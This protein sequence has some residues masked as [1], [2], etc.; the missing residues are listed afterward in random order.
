MQAPTFS[1]LH[2]HHMLR[3]S[4]AKSYFQ[5]TRLVQRH[6]RTT[7]YRKT[8]IHHLA[9]TATVSQ[10]SLLAMQPHLTGKH[11]KKQ[12]ELLD[13]CRMRLSLRRIEENKQKM[14]NL[15]RSF[16]F[17]FFRTEGKT[18]TTAILDL[19]SNTSPNRVAATPHNWIS[20]RK[21]Q[22][23][24]PDLPIPRLHA[25][26]RTKEEDAAP[27]HFHGTKKNTRNHTRR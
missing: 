10:S 11:K 8:T 21:H 12:R 6:R 23:K 15:Y 1:I 4:S 18:K 22:E 14:K 9:Q 20:R 17:D 3:F 26:H 16:P 27:Q 7:Q 19:S 5:R 13:Q 2:H 25:D 24:K